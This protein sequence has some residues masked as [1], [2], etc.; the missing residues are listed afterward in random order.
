MPRIPCTL[1]LSL[2]VSELAWLAEQAQ[3][4]GVSVE[5]YAVE[6]LLRE[7]EERDTLPSGLPPLEVGPT[8]SPE[9]PDVTVPASPYSLHRK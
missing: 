8:P 3:A 4:C 9:H 5:H 2:D 1:V 6:Y 7:F